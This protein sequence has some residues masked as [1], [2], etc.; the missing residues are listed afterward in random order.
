MTKVGKLFVMFVFALSF[1]FLACSI[2]MYSVR[3]KWAM[4]PDEKS[5]LKSA[6]GEAR[7]E[8]L[9]KDAG[10]VDRLQARIDDLAFARDLAQY[11][12]DRGFQTMGS[13]EAK[14][15]ERQLFYQ[16]KL[17]MLKTG[18]DAQGQLVATPAQKLEYDPNREVI[19]TMMGKDV[20]AY[21][22]QPLTSYDA[23]N[24]SRAVAEKDV[25][26]TQAKIKVEQAN[27]AKLTE[28]IQG[29]G[30]QGPVLNPGLIKLKELQDDAKL[31]A[32]AEQE[33]L[34]PA[35]ANRFGE[36]VLLLK[37]QQALLQRKQEMEKAGPVSL[38]P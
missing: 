6:T 25:A 3:V 18:K 26:D 13:L 31:R 2:G 19:A 36:A 21:R 1:F 38:N 7:R 32:M 8:M 22:G 29:G 33:F 9:E 37:R 30:E 16:A 10:V 5:K 12:Y 27:Y 15:A 23:Y 28:Q 20:I 14:R 24:S 35:L 4:A 11:R 17:A 34:K